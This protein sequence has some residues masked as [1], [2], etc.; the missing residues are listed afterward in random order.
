MNKKKLSKAEKI[1]KKKREKTLRIAGFALAAI[2]LVA[3]IV[4]SVMLSYLDILPFEFKIL[5]DILLVLF[6]MVTA[7]TQRWII[8]GALTKLLSIFMSIILAAGSFYINVTYRTIEKISGSYTKVSTMAVYVLADN[9]AESI[10]DLEGSV[11][12]IIANLEREDTD[13]TIA[14]IESTLE[15]EIECLEYE[16]I[17]DLADSLLN[18]ETDAIIMNSNYLAM[19]EDMDG[20]KDFESQIKCVMSYSI[21]KVIVESEDNEDYLTSDDCFSIYISGIDVPGSPN[22]NRNSDVNIIC[23]VNTRTHQVLLISTPRDFYV[24]LSISNGVCD[25]LTH[26]G[27]YGVDVSM[28][29]LEMLYGINIDYYLKVNFTGFVEIIDALGGIDVYSAYDFTSYHGGDH[30]NVGMNSVNGTQALGF[31]RERYSFPD[32]DKQRG[33]NQMEVIKGVIN[34]MLSTEMLMNYSNIMAAVSDSMITSMPQEEIKALVKSQLESAPSW[35]I[36]TYSVNGTGANEYSYSLPNLKTYVM[37][38]DQTTIDQ[39]KT[40]L[41]LMHNNQIITIE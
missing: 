19:L 32:G 25:K 5:I 3:T 24:P 38:P 23:T 10:V 29:T 4:F 14:K 9:P 39:A 16:G 28:D 35:E 18:E 26:A 13:S 20:Y 17:V 1:A 11:Y 21:E 31:A 7:I 30:F 27:A 40:Y 33:R 12:G 2:Q 6:C 34:K 22:E 36:L 8:P 37:V 15:T 41:D